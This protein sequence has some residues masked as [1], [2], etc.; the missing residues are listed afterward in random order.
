MKINYFLNI[1]NYFLNMKT[2]KQFS[3]FLLFFEWCE[4]AIFFEHESNQ[5]CRGRAKP[6]AP[7]EGAD[8]FG[9][10]SRGPT[11]LGAEVW[12]STKCNTGPSTPWTALR[13]EGR[14]TLF[15]CNLAFLDLKHWMPWY[16]VIR[17]P[18]GPI[19]LRSVGGVAFF[20]PIMEE[21]KGPPQI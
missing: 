11:I 19:W 6:S 4:A 10:K 17:P 2:V 16:K 18:S 15:G 20:F 8:H 3:I 12:C 13:M 21:K 5:C 7:S 14:R 9:G 1:G